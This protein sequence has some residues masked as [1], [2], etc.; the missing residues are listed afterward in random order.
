M[1]RSRPRGPAGRPRR[2]SSEEDRSV[3]PLYRAGLC[4]CW[5]HRADAMAG[6]D[7]TSRRKRGLF[8]PS[9]ST[10]T[11]GASGAVGRTICPPTAGRAGRAP[12]RLRERT[13]PLSFTHSSESPGVPPH[14]GGRCIGSLA[15]EGAPPPCPGSASGRGSN[16]GGP[17]AASLSAV[18][19]SG[20]A[21]RDP[22]PAVTTHRRVT[23]RNQGMTAPDSA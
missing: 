3:M 12:D 4:E 23:P 18:A 6:S 7:R 21:S 11:R 22:L 14:P 15:G 9:G 1:H 8:F 10:S 19:L 2:P 20:R 13:I 5:A 16:P 17:H